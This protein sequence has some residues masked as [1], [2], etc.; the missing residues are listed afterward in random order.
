MRATLRAYLDAGLT[1][2]DRAGVDHPP[3]HGQPAAAPDR[4][5]DR[6]RPRSPT[7]VVDARAALVLMDVAE[8]TELSRVDGPS[9]QAGWTGGPFN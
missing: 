5:V 1:A 4:R 8:G 9:V 3:E 6:P 2:R 7:A